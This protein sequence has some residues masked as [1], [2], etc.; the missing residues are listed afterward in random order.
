MPSLNRTPSGVLGP[1]FWVPPLL[2][3]VELVE[4]YP[5][6]HLASKLLALNFNHQLQPSTLTINSNLHSNNPHSILNS[7]ST[8]N[9]NTNSIFNSNPPLNPSNI[10][11]STQFSLLK[12]NNLTSILTSQ[13]KHHPN[14]S[15][16]T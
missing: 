11:F 7:N 6:L 3:T 2:P 8:L 10:N 14:L 9:F 1:A 12:S 13:I 15:L 16:Q 5:K 4:R